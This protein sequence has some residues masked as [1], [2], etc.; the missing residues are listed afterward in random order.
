MLYLEI[1]DQILHKIEKGD[2][3]EKLPSEAELAKAMNV[4]R[5][6][7]REALKF[8]QMESVL[9][10]RNG[11]GTYVNLKSALI[12]NSLNR[13]KSLGEMIRDAGYQE[14][15]TDVRIYTMQPE[16]DWKNKLQ[17]QKEMFVMERTRTAD[18][19]KVAFY[20]NILPNAFVCGKIGE[21]FSGS[22]FAFLKENLNIHVA[23]AVSEI[24]VTDEASER[25]RKAVDLLG[26]GVILLKQLHYDVNG[27]P[28]LY[29][30]DYLKSSAFH[31]IVKRDI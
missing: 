23:Y 26:G 2:Y 25:D 4:S 20:Y 22:L 3:E 14:S 12:S 19:Q 1:K 5:S 30:L 9:V 13:L 27:R 16:E 11:V 24:C 17:S 7:V 8:L 28:V 6:T 10:S 31:L 15:E 21:D 18:G 29:S